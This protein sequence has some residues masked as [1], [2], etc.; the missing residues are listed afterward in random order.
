MGSPKCT[1]LGGGFKCDVCGTVTMCI[2]LVMEA[3]KCKPLEQLISTKHLYLSLE[4]AFQPR[5]CICGSHST[6]RR[7][8]GRL[9]L[10]LYGISG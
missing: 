10:T 7:D 2:S 8:A 9:K 3:L 6:S 1:S 5:D 4:H